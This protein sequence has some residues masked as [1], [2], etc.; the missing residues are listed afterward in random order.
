ML[1][2]K[3]LK[4]QFRQRW[5]CKRKQN[6]CGIQSWTEK[7]LIGE[8]LNYLQVVVFT[9]IRISRPTWFLKIK[10]AWSKHSRYYILL[11]YSTDHLKKVFTSCRLN[12]LG[13]WGQELKEFNN[14]VTVC[15]RFDPGSSQKLK[16]KTLRLKK[17]WLSEKLST[18]NIYHFAIPGNSTIMTYLWDTLS[19][20][21]GHVILWHIALLKISAATPHGRKGGFQFTAYN[22]NLL[23][24]RT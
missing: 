9:T 20:L 22:F 23:K 18:I 8:K 19:L 12:D 13:K 16:K 3:R 6:S 7:V 4:D 10:L 11:F 5:Q 2:E 17:N 24:W 1:I 14:F 21:S 15:S